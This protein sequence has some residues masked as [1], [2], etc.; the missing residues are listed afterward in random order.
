MFS[1]FNKFLIVLTCLGRRLCKV[2]IL[3]KFI[4]KMYILFIKKSRISLLIML[5]SGEMCCMN[6]KP[7][8]DYIW[9]T[10]FGNKYLYILVYENI[11]TYLPFFHQVEEKKLQMRIVPWNEHQHGYAIFLPFVGQQ[12][13]STIFVT[14]QLRVG[15]P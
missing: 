9:C 4:K 7:G 15:L 14:L 6:P 10:G 13:I 5:W 12:P 8:I 11:K 2:N 1:M 3:Y